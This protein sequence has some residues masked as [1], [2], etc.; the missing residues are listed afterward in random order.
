M[1]AWLV[2]MA[3][4]LVVACGA[5]EPQDRE[6]SLQ[7]RDGQLADSRESLEVRRGDRVTLAITSDAGVKLHLHGYDIS[8]S[9]APENTATIE[10]TAN[11]SGSFPL[12]IHRRS[13]FNQDTGHGSHAA[14]VPASDGMS[15]A[16]AVHADA[17]DG[18][19]VHIMP[20]GFTF[21]PERVNEAHVP[22]EG[23][24]HI[25]LDGV[26]LGRVYGPYYHLTGVEAGEHDVKV[27]LNANS[28]EGYAR[29]GEPVAAVAVIA[30][31]A[32]SAGA[33]HG[34]DHSEH[35]EEEATLLRLEVRP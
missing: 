4:V 5:N 12:T 18:F 25:Y 32:S 31:E 16:I 34:D 21:S 6:F 19:N 15:V 9:A 33:E 29:A 35:G 26:K 1:R 3:A 30:G 8:A 28:H 24:A 23:H 2:T 20:K 14:T 11:A 7:I 27:T 22:G 10:L 17:V 13:S